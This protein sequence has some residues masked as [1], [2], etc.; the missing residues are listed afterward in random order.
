M[1]LQ[2]RKKHRFFAICLVA[3]FALTT[4]SLPVCAS[5]DTPTP[6]PPPPPQPLFNSENM[7]TP[8]PGDLLIGED[9]GTA[10]HI[11]EPGVPF[12]LTGTIGVQPVK[13][14]I[15]ELKDW[16][17]QAAKEEGYADGEKYLSL[18]ELSDV[19]CTFETFLYLPEGLEFKTD[20]Y[21]NA[22]FYDNSLFYASA[23]TYDKDPKKDL[24]VE[25][26]LKKNYN[27]FKTLCEDVNA[28]PDL[29]LDA[30][31]I[32]A[33][34]KFAGKEL[35]ATGIVKGHFKATATFM[36][37]QMTFPFGWESEQDPKG[38]DYNLPADD[39]KTISYTV[40]VKPAPAPEEEQDIL[41]PC[42]YPCQVPPMWNPPQ[43]IQQ[44]QPMPQAPVQ[45]V[46]AAQPQAPIQ[47]PKTGEKSTQPLSL[48]FLLSAS[49]LFLLRRKMR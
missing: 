6:P 49:A 36:G 32:V 21:E 9:S 24:Y 45:N 41:I 13:D 40:T 16:F 18:I 42:P 1:K 48:F 37:L 33:D 11:V 44:V 3:V 15:N 34:P 2:Q 20:S 7:I 12:T 28:C 31:N 46:D 8:L 17:L 29:R 14:Q 47:L 43:V 27:N 19:E 22:K 38:K 5:E 39:N 25:M 35:Q 30:G 4:L 26:K 10:P 23:T